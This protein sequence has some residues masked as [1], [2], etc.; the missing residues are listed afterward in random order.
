MTYEM[1]TYL[2]VQETTNKLI[3]KNLPRLIKGKW[4]LKTL[5]PPKFRLLSLLEWLNP[6][7][8]FINLDLAKNSWL[9]KIEREGER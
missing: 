9:I 7:F 4:T 8:R 3:I 2:K 1:E 6:Y 5:N